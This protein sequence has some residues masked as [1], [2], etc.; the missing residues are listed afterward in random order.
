MNNDYEKAIT[1]LVARV[2]LSHETEWSPTE[3]RKECERVAKALE[4]V[5]DML[6]TTSEEMRIE[7]VHQQRGEPET[8]TGIDGLPQQTQSKI[9]WPGYQAIKWQI[10]S[11]AESARMAADE[12]PHHNEKF[13]LRHAAM[14]M[15]ILRHFYDFAPATFYKDG[16]A[17][18]ELERIA[19][20]AG[21]F[22]TREAYLKVLK[23]TIKKFDPHYTPPEFLYLF[24]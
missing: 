7:A 11:L 23:E 22:L 12:L 16:E 2:R 14:G 21:I 5:A 24:K 4:K 13:A 9:E 6:S 19:E 3:S 10:R 1:K 15:L 20:L 8:F 17:V 18:I